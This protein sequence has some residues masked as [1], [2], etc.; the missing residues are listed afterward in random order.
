MN[1]TLTRK[2]KVASLLA[3]ASLVAPL[4]N[5]APA[6]ADPRQISSSLATV[7][8]DT[9]QEVLNAFQGESAGTFY[10][11]LATDGAT[12]RTVIMSWEAK[13]PTGTSGNTIACVQTKLGGATFTR[14]NGSSAGRRAL[15]RAMSNESYGDATCGGAKPVSGLI[16]IARSSDGPAS[17]D[18][19]TDLTYVPFARDALSFAYYPVNG[20]TPDASLSRA[21]LQAIFDSAGNG[22]TVG[23]VLF[24]PCH[25]QI[26][27]GTRNSWSAA[28]GVVNSEMDTASTTCTNTGVQGLLQESKPSELKAKGDAWAAANPGVPAQFIVGHSASAF[29]A[30][31]RGAAPSFLAAGVDLGSITDN[32]SGTNLGKPYTGS[33][34]TAAASP[35]F[36]N[37][38]TFG[39]FVYNV[40]STARITSAIGNLSLKQML[41]GPGSQ[42]CTAG[43]S[44]ITNFGFLQLPLGAENQLGQCGS[45]ALTGSKLTGAL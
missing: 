43:A 36:Y 39:R 33:G 2:A 7:G 16:D 28:V 6:S 9:T 41:R 42:V 14:P 21:E 19:G 45:I 4:F 5:S 20:A 3:A 25:I 13:A 38:S 37:D 8:S 27:S 17:G 29:V 40:V 24:I 22:H 10:T 1:T 31:S 26:G 18:T 32:G 44:R 15:S 11:P 30:Q 23:G 35:T 34:A 12:G